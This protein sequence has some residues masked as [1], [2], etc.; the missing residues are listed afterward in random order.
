MEMER[1]NENTIRV[2]IGNDDLDKRGITV[3]DLLGNH[4]QIESFFYSILE[5]VDK[6]HQF[7]NNDAV[8]FQV[9]PNQNGL[10][11][12][13]SKDVDMSD[14]DM[15][16]SGD[17]DSQRP[18]KRDRVSKYIAEH[19][20]NNKPQPVSD[21]KTNDEFGH[22][23][24]TVIL[25]FDQL[26]DFVSLAKALRLEN[27]TSDLYLYEGKY[28]L[29]LELFSN[30]PVDMVVSDEVAIANEYGKKTTVT[31]EVLNE[32]GQHIM[33]NSALELSRYYFK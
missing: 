21:K 11:L 25:E 14:N 13:I 3:L 18:E 32:Y 23:K 27:G 22:Q 2:L 4:K 8:T 7:Q 31:E 12:F 30:D 29:K 28:Y 6:D 16:D 10:E 17:A 19:A 15:F 20:D 5:E 33:E 1:I 26:N 24:R 9:L